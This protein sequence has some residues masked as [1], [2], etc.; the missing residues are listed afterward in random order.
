MSVRRR[1]RSIGG[2]FMRRMGMLPG[3]IP[4]G[5]GDDA[6]LLGRTLEQQVVAFFPD[7]VEG[8]YQ[9]R[10]WY[11]PLHALDARRGVLVVASDSRTARAIR[12]E[13]QLEVV[14]VAHYATLDDLVSRGDVRLALYVNHNPLNFSMMRFG[15]M[16]HVSLLHGDSDKVV[17]VSNQ[18]KAYDLSFVAGQAAVDRLGTYLYHF[19][20]TTRCVPVGR[21]Q[22]DEEPLVV[23]PRPDADERTTVLYAPT[24]EGAQPSAAYGSTELMGPRLVSALLADGRFRVVARPHPLSGVRSPSY[25]EA[26]AA[27]RRLIAAAADAEPQVGHRMSAGESLSAAFDAADL[28]VCDVSAVAMDWLPTRRP[29]VVTDPRHPGVRTASTRMLGTVPRLAAEDLDGVAELLA[30]EAVEDPGRKEREAMVSYY[31]GDTTPGASTTRF[32][33]ACDAALEWHCTTLGVPVPP[34]RDA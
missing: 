27:V 30:R 31:L 9:L 6:R 11:A 13:T 34:R 25:G 4:D 3:G 12:A 26:D 22:L 21:P 14:T 23:G 29:L 17:S 20:A 8:L 7:T 28:L 24:W 33:D 18:A 5:L 15:S 10:Q 19:D 16:V 2:R 1:V 32:L